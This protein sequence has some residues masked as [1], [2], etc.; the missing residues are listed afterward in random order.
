MNDFYESGERMRVGH[1]MVLSATFGVFLSNAT[2]WSD[3]LHAA[4]DLAFPHEGV[5]SA[6]V[7]ASVLTCV[8]IPL[9]VGLIRISTMLQTVDVSRRVT[10]AR[11][12][13]VGR[14]AL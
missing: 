13:L 10:R 11:S 4:I 2:A 3:A 9:L 5:A 12:R 8:S 1:M 14:P 6:L 7:S